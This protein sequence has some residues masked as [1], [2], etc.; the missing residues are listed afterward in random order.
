[1]RC[2]SYVTAA[3]LRRLELADVLH[4]TPACAGTRAGHPKRVHVRTTTGYII[5]SED[6]GPTA[7]RRGTCPVHGPTIPTLKPWTPAIPLLIR[8]FGFR[9]PRGEC[10]P[11]GMPGWAKLK[12]H[13]ITRRSQMKPGGFQPSSQH[14]PLMAGIVSVLTNDGTRQIDEGG[15]GVS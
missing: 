9:I 11:R 1:M 7:G 12:R 2:Q 14:W 8:G 4:A 6:H 3:D 15:S 10:L 13:E 5:Q